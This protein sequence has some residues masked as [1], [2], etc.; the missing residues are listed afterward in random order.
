MNE[1]L[2]PKKAPPVTTATIK[3]ISMPVC[4]AIPTPTGVG[5]TSVPT[6]VPTDNDTKQ[7]ATKIQ[8]DRKCQGRR[9]RVRLT[10]VS[11][12]PIVLAA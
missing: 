8:A 3:G 7:E 11:D 6:E 10:A 1:R 9:D 12:A 5:A 2:S 4:S